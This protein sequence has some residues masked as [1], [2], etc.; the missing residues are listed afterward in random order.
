MG[1]ESRASFV[2][3]GYVLSHWA[4]E[5]SMR[6]KCVRVWRGREC[7]LPRSLPLLSPIVTEKA[8]GGSIEDPGSNLAD[9]MGLQAGPLTSMSSPPPTH[10]NSAP[11]LSVMTHSL[12]SCTSPKAVQVA[13]TYSYVA[14]QSNL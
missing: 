3:Q 4:V 6:G 11:T 2:A 1:R 8:V 7:S 13:D 12:H 9:E 5:F 14:Y 10:H